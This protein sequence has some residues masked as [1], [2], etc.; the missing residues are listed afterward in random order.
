MTT[1][2]P[3]AL[4]H[5]PVHTLQE[6]KQWTLSY[7]RIVGSTRSE[8]RTADGRRRLDLLARDGTK[9]EFQQSKETVPN[10]HGKELAHASGLLWVFCTIN[11]HDRGD[12]LLTTRHGA[13]VTFEWKRPWKLIASC[14]GRVL[15]DLGRSAQVGDHVLLEL[16]HFA[17]E[18]G[19]AT[20]TGVL[21]DAQEFCYWMRDGSPLLPYAWASRAA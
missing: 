4:V 6:R 16:D 9:C 19:R 18:P 10:T 21:R 14:N 13:R 8:I 17:I 5:T 3:F 11:Q 15:L 12:L 7:Q 2:Q 20:G 1:S